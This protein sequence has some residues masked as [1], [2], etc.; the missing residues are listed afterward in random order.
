MFASLLASSNNFFQFPPDFLKR[1]LCEN[2]S[3]SLIVENSM[4][5]GV[6]GKGVALKSA[7]S[8]KDAQRF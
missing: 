2:V 4:I 7:A 5:E 8:A 1:G 6:G 3:V